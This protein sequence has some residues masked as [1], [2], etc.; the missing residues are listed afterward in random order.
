MLEHGRRDSKGRGAQSP[1]PI[2][3]ALQALTYQIPR[4]GIHGHGA[5]VEHVAPREEIS[6]NQH[7]ERRQG[8]CVH[9]YSW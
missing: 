6:A 4:L 1:R 2:R 5:T 8:L 9:S 7:A 3:W